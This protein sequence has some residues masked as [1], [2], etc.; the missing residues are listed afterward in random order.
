LSNAVWSWLWWS[1]DRLGGVGGDGHGIAGG[2]GERRVASAAPTGV[3]L[4]V[5]GGWGVARSGG[6][7]DRSGV[8]AQGEPE[9]VQPV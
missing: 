9:V 8:V 6:L 1:I 2:Q 4:E 3:L 5:L 7:G